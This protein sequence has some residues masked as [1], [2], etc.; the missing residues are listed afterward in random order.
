MTY[1]AHASFASWLMTHDRSPSVKKHG[2]LAG[3]A[4]DIM[5][6]QLDEASSDPATPDITLQLLTQGRMDF[7]ADFGA[8]R[9]GGMMRPG[10]LVVAPDGVPLTVSG[11][12]QCEFL[13]LAIPGS[14]MRSAAASFTDASVIDLEPLFGRTRRDAQIA[15]LIGW[16]WTEADENE[17]ASRLTIDGALMMITAGLLRQAGTPPS[18]QQGGLAAWQVRRAIEMIEA[19]LGTEM[20]LSDLA[21]EVGLSP[22]HF[23]RAFKA[24]TG[25]P[26]HAY[27]TN[28]R[29][30]RAKKLLQQ[31]D[32][33]VTEI[34]FEVGYESSQALARLFRRSVGES[35]S[36]YRRGLRA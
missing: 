16:L 36:A 31:S 12:G 29:V 32:I 11:R 2:S 13:V 33:P 10:D 3:A 7:A 14:T 18:Y 22:Y 34:A 5:R 28:L 25:K 35:P 1:P 9:F 8:K 26:P 24:S 19:N 17:G 15:T 27:Q 20:R 23:A 4:A 21:A 6:V 30:E